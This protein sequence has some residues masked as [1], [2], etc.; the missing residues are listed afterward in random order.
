MSSPSIN[1]GINN[2]GKALVEK[3]DLHFS[4]QEP[5][6]YKDFILSSTIEIEKDKNVLSK[7]KNGEFETSNDD[8]IKSWFDFELYAHIKNL[9]SLVN[10]SISSTIIVNIIVPLA[11]QHSTSQLKK[12]LEAVKELSDSQQISGT[13]I[14]IFAIAYSVG[15]QNY[16]KNS[17]I[18]NELLILEELTSEYDSIINDIYYLDDRSTDKVVLNLDLNWLAFAL[19]EFFVFQMVSQT[20]LAIQNKSKIFGIGVIHFNEIL[21]R[22]VIA[23][24]ILQYKFEEEGIVEDE[25]VQLRDVINKCNP[26]IKEHQ[27]FFK[28]FLEKH[29][30]SVDNNRGLTN[31]SKNYIDSFRAKLEDF[32]TDSN[33]T[34]GESKVV[35]A[36][37]LGE[38]DKILEG[39]NWGSERL[40]ISDLEFDI[41]DYFNTYLEEDERVDFNGQK[42]LRNRI[43]EYKQAI[44]SDEKSIKGLEEQSEEIHSDLDIA[45]E[46]GIF[47]VNGKRINASGYIPSAINPN[48][49]FYKYIDKPIS[50]SVDLTKYFSKVKDQGQ[51]LSCTAFPVSAV[52]EFAAKQNSKNV[53]ISELFIYYNTRELRGNITE[54]TGATL[55]ETINS[56]KEKG[57]CYTENHPYAIDALSNKPSEIAYTEAQH[58]V[59]EKAC[60]VNISEKDFKYAIANGHPVIIGLKLFKSFYPKDIT[61]VI[62]FPSD[63]EAEY[64]NYGNHAL[65]VVGYN[66][67]E[68]LFKLR[69]SWGENFGESGY[70][71][72]PYDYIANSEYCLEAFIISNIIDLSYNE[73]TYDTNTSFTFLK[74]SITRKKIIKE[75]HLRVKKREL[76][77]TKKEYDLIALK[78]EENSEKIK[79]PLFR[80]RL[81]DKLKEQIQAVVVSPPEPIKQEPNK[82]KAWFFIGG[83]ILLIFLSIIINLYITTI[84]TLIGSLLSIALIIFGSKILFTK[85][86]QLRIQTGIE[87]PNTSREIDLYKFEVADRL[88]SQF[89]DMN[90]NLIIRYKALSK[91]FE[92]V[93]KWQK[94]S[95]K[96]L[97]EIEYSSATFVIN[98]VREKPLLDYLANEK[99]LFLDNLPNLSAVFNEKYS[100]INNNVNEVFNQLKDNYKDDIKK[101][102]DN[103]LDI[104]IVDYIQGKRTY[105][106]FDPV[107]ELSIIMKNIEKVSAPFCNIKQTTNSLN[108]QNYVIHEKIPSTSQS[109]LQ[110]FSKHRGAAIN[111]VLS[112]RE[113]KKKYVAI[114]VSALNNISDLVRYNL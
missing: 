59:V 8:N 37:L 92:K 18:K 3:I 108:I 53:D 107:P 112:F 28:R 60:R 69:N 82:K 63:N 110:E 79:N 70:C 26:F 98:V 86:E 56:V 13:D 52:Y 78:N 76:Y 11:E 84:G 45:F 20:S 62:P 106:Y 89:D 36:N 54:D 14:K 35:L 19:G 94:D 114:Q 32:V 102:I 80:K 48:D 90:K 25:G 7:L 42:K 81:F 2:Q 57:A 58:Q 103:I 113:N 46:E 77:K 10:K 61:G 30:Y 47:S 105:P 27:N 22:N 41:L 4:D 100:P 31:N 83:G 38:D 97:N 23:N 101:N 33:N 91:Y 34:I 67:E 87:N 39:I 44:K 88:F 75:Y 5:E 16:D 43:T 1:I 95:Y 109:G 93:K 9:I 99:L 40:N 6:F 29:P 51:M 24:K 55:L 64:E 72:A 104:S 21:F 65:L 111:P 49:E 74:D 50:K 17:H 66:D 71:Y 15:E 68:K 96:T 85:I 12:L 73:F